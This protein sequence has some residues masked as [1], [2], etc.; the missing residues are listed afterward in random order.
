M[1]LGNIRFEI[2]H[3]PVIVMSSRANQGLVY[4]CRVHHALQN[5]GVQNTPSIQQVYRLLGI[6]LMGTLPELS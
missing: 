1:G 4:V 2:Q 3:E 5:K 6:A